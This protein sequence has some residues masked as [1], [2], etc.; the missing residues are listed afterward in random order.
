MGGGI[1]VGEGDGRA[2]RHRDFLGGE[3]EVR[4]LDR[5]AVAGGRLAGSRFVA[6]AGD[7][8]ECEGRQCDGYGGSQPARNGWTALVT[9]STVS[10]G[11]NASGAAG[12]PAA[13]RT[14]AAWRPSTGRSPRPWPGGP[15]TRSR[16]RRRCR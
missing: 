3:L 14:A 16:G 1:L 2:R 6:A 15:W 13:L 7:P 12:S 4:D 5:V 9:S 11:S 8:R 10:V